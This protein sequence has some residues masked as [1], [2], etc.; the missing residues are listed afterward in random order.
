MTTRWFLGMYPIRDIDIR[1]DRMRPNVH[2]LGMFETGMF[3]GC[4]SVSSEIDWPVNNQS[5]RGRLLST[6]NVV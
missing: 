1:T 4:K 2:E 3:P 6:G 5:R